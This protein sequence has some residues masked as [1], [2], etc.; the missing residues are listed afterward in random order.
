MKTELNTLRAAQQKAADAA[1]EL[2]RL[3]ELRA[4][5]SE[6]AAAINTGIATD[7]GAL[8]KARQD[9]LAAVA[10]GE[11][12]QDA[13][14]SVDQAIEEAEAR[15]AAGRRAA[16]DAE[17]A[18]AGLARR[19][20]AAESALQAT[21]DELAAAK[22]ACLEAHA[23]ELGRQYVERVQAFAAIYRRLFSLHAI[24]KRAGCSQGTHSPYGSNDLRIPWFNYPQDER[25][26]RQAARRGYLFDGLDFH[27]AGGDEEWRKHEVEFLKG[28][29]VEP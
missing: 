10:A 21:R 16:A 2:E 5:Q 1:A 23:D 27:M 15:T 28:I 17:Q 12:D 7:T 8:R 9:T 19:I 11:A 26:G 13:L 3:Q 22:R 20:E 4:Q 25:A 29:G 24:L 18:A 14:V 6:A